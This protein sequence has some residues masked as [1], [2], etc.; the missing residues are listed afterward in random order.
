MLFKGLHQNSTLKDLSMGSIKI[1]PNAISVD[2]MKSLSVYL[3][4]REKCTL[5]SLDLRHCSIEAETAVELA[6]GLKHNC[7]MK[8]L[9]LNYNHVGDQGA[10]ALGQALLQNKTLMVLSLVE[11]GITTTGATAL[12]VCNCWKTKHLRSFTLPAMQ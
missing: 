11:C 2:N 6:H 10:T 7:S 8:T 9:N 12:A 3:Q 1:I 5:E 4:D